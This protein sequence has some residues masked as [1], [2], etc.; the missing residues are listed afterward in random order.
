[1]KDLFENFGVGFKDLDPR[2]QQEALVIAKQLMEKDS[3][4]SREAAIKEAIKQAE[5]RFLDLEG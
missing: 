2:V 4:I 3:K 1:M 5:Q